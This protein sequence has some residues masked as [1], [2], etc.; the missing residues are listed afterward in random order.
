MLAIL[1]WHRQEVAPQSKR[2]WTQAHTGG[3]SPSIGGRPL[4]ALTPEVILCSLWE[5]SRIS[6]LALFWWPNLGLYHAPSASRSDL[7]SRLSNSN[8]GSTTRLWEDPIRMSSGAPQN[9][10][11][12]SCAR[13]RVRK[14]L[15]G[16]KWRPGSMWIWPGPR[17]SH[18]KN[19]ASLGSTRP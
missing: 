4:I 10:W 18:S 16:D 8:Q 15:E 12:T 19:T 7:L 14:H 5:S 1:R 17:I 11:L 13:Q 2:R 9:T 6:V 3:L